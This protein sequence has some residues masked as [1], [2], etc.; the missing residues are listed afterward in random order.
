MT[1]HALRATSLVFFFYHDV[2]TL[3]MVFKGVDDVGR[4]LA[5][6][7]TKRFGVGCSS[8]PGGKLALSKMRASNLAPSDKLSPANSYS[9]DFPSPHPPAEAIAHGEPAAPIVASSHP[10]PTV[11][12]A[13]PHPQA[14]KGESMIGASSVISQPSPAAHLS[15]SFTESDLLSN[16]SHLKSTFPS[17]PSSTQTSDSSSYHQQSALGASTMSATTF[18]SAGAGPNCPQTPSDTDSSLIQRGTRTRN[19]WMKVSVL[20]VLGRNFGSHPLSALRMA[21][22]SYEPAVALTQ[23][24]LK[25]PSFGEDGVQ[26]ERFAHSIMDSGVVDRGDELPMLSELLH[27]THEVLNKVLSRET[28]VKKYLPAQKAADFAPN[29]PVMTELRKVREEVEKLEEEYQSENDLLAAEFDA[30]SFQVENS[31]PVSREHAAS[32]KE[33]QHPVSDKPGVMG[34]PVKKS[35]EEMG[36]PDK[37]RPAGVGEPDKKRSRPSLE[38]CSAANQESASSVGEP[39]IAEVDSK[40]PSLAET[41]AAALDRF[42]K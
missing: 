22:K 29:G 19:S 13:L 37:K 9:R 38:G 35:S 39:T 4:P 42:Q 3:S 23:Q 30:D 5:K 32:V 34:S 17:L 41:G 21:F 24:S 25:G 7:V 10:A 11:D 16:N 2:K 31:M 12:P 40:K 15:Y 20:K 27:F 14:S 18:V 1:M 28:E 26:M 36:E 33:L 6:S 8:K